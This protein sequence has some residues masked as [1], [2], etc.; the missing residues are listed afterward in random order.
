MAASGPEKYILGVCYWSIVVIGAEMAILQFVN[1]AV[2]VVA[3]AATD[4][5]LVASI[6]TAMKTAGVRDT[7]LLLSPHLGNNFQ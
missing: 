2:P 1:I 4:T 7:S 3:Q 5:L 6:W